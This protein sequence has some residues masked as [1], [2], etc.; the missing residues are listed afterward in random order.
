[1][2]VSAHLNVVFWLKLV[3]VRGLNHT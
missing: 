3:S 1:M 2:V